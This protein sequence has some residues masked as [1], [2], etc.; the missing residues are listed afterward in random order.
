MLKFGTVKEL[1]R[2]R[3]DMPEAVYQKALEIVA[4]LDS[5]Y[6]TERTDTSDGGFCL[7]ATTVQDVDFI[8]KEYV[9]TNSGRHEF[10]EVIKGKEI[11]H[12]HALFLTNNEFGIN[13]F[14]LNY[15]IVPSVI[16]DDIEAT[17]RNIET[18]CLYCLRPF[19][20]NT[21]NDIDDMGWV[22]C[23]HCGGKH[24]TKGFI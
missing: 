7:I 13:V 15:G 8:N 14:F 10:A 18:D 6:G 3:H 17:G 24:E 5:E 9:R 4:M 21:A 2:I 19:T 20:F 11:D 16:L 22:S 23:P 12:V 1:G